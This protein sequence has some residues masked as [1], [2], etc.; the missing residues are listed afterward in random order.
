MTI[1]RRA[2][3]LALATMTL[4]GLATPAQAY[5]WEGR[6]QSTNVIDCRPENS[7]WLYRWW[8]GCSS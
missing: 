5:Q 7:T 2:I 4:S 1:F 8:H 6:R 3:V